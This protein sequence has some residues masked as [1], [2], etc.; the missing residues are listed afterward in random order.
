[1]SNRDVLIYRHEYI[2]NFNDIKNLKF[3]FEQGKNLPNV[4][5]L[6]ISSFETTMSPNDTTYR[7]YDIRKENNRVKAQRGYFRKVWSLN[8]KKP[9]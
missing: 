6:N 7:E 8:V 1:M 2:E 4:F 5:M 9:F 3:I